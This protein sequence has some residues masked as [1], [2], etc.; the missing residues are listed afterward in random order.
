MTDFAGG[1]SMIKSGKVRALAVANARRLPQL[2]DVPTFRELG[3]RE[4]LAE[5]FAGIVVPA[6]TPPDVIAR[7]QA[8]VAAA[9]RDP[10][11]NA[12]LVDIGYEPVGGTQQ[13]F[14]AVLQQETPRWH[15]LVKDLSI[16]LD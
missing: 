13:Q 7:L 5:A 14:V 2:P 9:V 15:K 12:K 3:L 1:G 8:A 10:Q 6:R 11:V 4:V 16:S